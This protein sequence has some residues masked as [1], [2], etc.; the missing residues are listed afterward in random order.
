MDHSVRR[1]HSLPVVLDTIE[2]P[3]KQ[4]FDLTVNMVDS[5]AECSYDNLCP[6]RGTTTLWVHRSCTVLAYTPLLWAFKLHVFFSQAVLFRA[7]RALSF[8]RPSPPVYPVALCQPP[9]LLSWEQL[10]NTVRQ[11]RINGGNLVAR[12]ESVLLA[13]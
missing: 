2:S 10:G 12:T 13:H 11:G 5:D 7:L 9:L 8:D 6:Q 3:Y 4:L 1:L